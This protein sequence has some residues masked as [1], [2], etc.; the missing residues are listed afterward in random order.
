MNRGIPKNVS[1]GHHHGKFEVGQ[2]LLPIFHVRSLFV[3]RT[4]DQEAAQRRG[5]KPTLK[6]RPKNGV[7]A[8]FEKKTPANGPF[9]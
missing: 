2:D 3:Y 6:A 7:F 8:S 1:G 5:K 9:R 4:Y